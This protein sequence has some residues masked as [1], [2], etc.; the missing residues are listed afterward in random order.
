MLSSHRLFARAIMHYVRRCIS[1]SVLEERKTKSGVAA[2]NASA[3]ASPA[4]SASAATAASPVP[5]AS[6]STV[7]TSNN[8]Y[9]QEDLLTD[10]ELAQAL[11]QQ[12]PCPAKAGLVAFIEAKPSG[13]L[14]CYSDFVTALVHM[15][16]TT[17]SRHIPA[18]MLRKN[19]Y[20]SDMVIP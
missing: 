16:R 12:W 4:S 1:S 11:Q 6:P 5:S 15:N 2:N 8:L 14:Y 17:F 7:A 9:R 18:D 3:G 10:M 20:G 19:I 13:E